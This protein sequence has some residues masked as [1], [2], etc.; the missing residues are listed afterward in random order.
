MTNTF[1]VHVVRLCTIKKA[2]THINPPI[3]TM[4]KAMTAMAMI[5]GL[6]YATLDVVHSVSVRVCM[7]IYVE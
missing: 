6:R 3:I 4:K 2:W 5:S 7:I 1:N